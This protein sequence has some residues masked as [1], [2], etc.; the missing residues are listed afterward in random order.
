LLEVNTYDKQVFSEISDELETR[1]SRA[2]ELGRQTA[3]EKSRV[4]SSDMRNSTEYEV[5]RSDTTMQMILGQGNRQVDYTKFQELGTKFIEGTHH[6]K[7]GLQR[8]VEE[9]NK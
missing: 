6:V 8:A 4:D 5:E 7:A 3:Y 9:F 1:L 2:G